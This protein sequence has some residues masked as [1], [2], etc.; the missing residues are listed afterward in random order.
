MAASK[1]LNVLPISIGGIVMSAALAEIARE[2]S[3]PYIPGFIAFSIVFVVVL[4]L[5]A[6]GRIRRARMPHLDGKNI[7]ELMT[8]GKAELLKGENA[9]RT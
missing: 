3:T 9:D 8:E 6:L 2:L 7:F 1:K 4:G 5:L